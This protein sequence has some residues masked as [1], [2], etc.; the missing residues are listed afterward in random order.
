M[1][2]YTSIYETVVH[3]MCRSRLSPQIPQIW[4]SSPHLAMCWFLFPQ[5]FLDA[6]KKRCIHVMKGKMDD[7]QFCRTV[8]NFCIDSTDIH[9]S[10]YL[11][12]YSKYKYALM[13]KKYPTVHKTIQ[14][15]VVELSNS[16]IHRTS[17]YLYLVWKQE[18]EFCIVLSTGTPYFLYFFYFDSS[19]QIV[20]N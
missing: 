15:P 6:Y 7:G 12:F 1:Y 9:T 17:T 2:L 11:C 3:E 13:V 10:W 5:N 20:L 19:P 4:D 16:I 14:Q 8:Q 18:R